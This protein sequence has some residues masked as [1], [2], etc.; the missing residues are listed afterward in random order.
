MK[1][2]VTAINR[3]GVETTKGDLE[4]IF[5]VDLFEETA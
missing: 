3:P 1:A 4:L 2:P 5:N